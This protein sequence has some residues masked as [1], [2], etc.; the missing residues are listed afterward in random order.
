[1]QRIIAALL[2]QSEFDLV[3]FQNQPSSGGD[4]VPDAQI[5]SSCKLLFETKIK[6]GTT[7]ETQLRRHLQRLDGANEVTKRLLLLTP[8]SSCP[9]EVESIADERLVWASFESLDQAINELI[10]DPQEVISEREQFLLRELQSMFVR[11]KLVGSADVL[12]VPARSAWPEYQRHAA[13]I[14]QPDR[15]FRSVDRVAFYTGGKIWPSVP[16]IL[17]TWEHVDWAKGAYSGR[18]GEVVDAVFDDPANT[19]ME[20]LAYKVMILSNKDSH[21]T[22]QLMQPV[23]NNLTS[24]NGRTVAFTQNQRYVSLDKLLKAKQTSDLV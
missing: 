3:E 12:V 2:E 13:Y 18:L 7:D 14:C 23:E 21:D 15:T 5:S 22:I 19:R 10:A 24:D 17:E 1:M 9:V 6:S 16:K 4:G 20:G 8:D 11:E